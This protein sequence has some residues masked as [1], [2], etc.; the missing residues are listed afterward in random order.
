ML[1]HIPGRQTHTHNQ[2]SFNASGVKLLSLTATEQETTASSDPSEAQLEI[3]T[4]EFL[5]SEPETIH[6]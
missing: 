5:L 4:H 1:T 3:Q 6:K 2:I